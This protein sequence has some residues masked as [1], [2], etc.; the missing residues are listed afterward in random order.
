MS[1]ATKSA[2]SGDGWTLLEEVITKDILRAEVQAWCQRLDVEL[3]ELHIRLMTR[4]WGSLSTSG[5]MTLNQELLTKPS[6]FRRQVIVH[7]LLH[8]KVPNHGR[9]FKSLLRAYLGSELS[10]QDQSK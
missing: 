8:L 2:T 9:L 1:Q 7:E 4:K 3:K 5:R 10:N 6:D